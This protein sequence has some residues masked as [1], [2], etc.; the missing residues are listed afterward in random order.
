MQSNWTKEINATIT[1]CDENGTIIYLNDKALKE[2]EDD[3]GEKLIG[4][5]LL[6]CHPE[7]HK[8]KLKELM[9]S[10][11]VSCY[12][13]EKNGKKKLVYHTPWFDEGKYKGYVEMIIG[14]PFDM[15]HFVRD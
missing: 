2:F 4:T 3:G 7:P 6:D 10:K 5:K 12:T 15:P 13:I 11:N 8:T 9:S 1:V 14:I